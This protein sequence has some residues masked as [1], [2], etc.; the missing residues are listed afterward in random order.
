MIKKID[1]KGSTDE[2]SLDIDLIEEADY[3]DLVKRIFSGPDELT[4][5]VSNYTGDL[6]RLK[7]HIA[8]LAFLLERLYRCILLAGA[9]C[10]R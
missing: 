4:V 1:I 3:I 7:N 5:R 9:S 8:L 10:F 6:N 2:E